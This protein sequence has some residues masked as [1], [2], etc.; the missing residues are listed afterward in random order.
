VCLCAQ[1]QLSWAGGEDW[2]LQQQQLR[3]VGWGPISALLVPA[4]RLGGST[5][6]GSS[7][8][9]SFFNRLLVQ[10]LTTFLVQLLLLLQGLPCGPGMSPSGWCSPLPTPPTLWVR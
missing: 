3:N 2:V 9:S 8:S 6:T 5:C 7:S 10:G 1:Q 4:E